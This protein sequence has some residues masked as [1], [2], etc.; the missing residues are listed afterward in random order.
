MNMMSSTTH[1]HKKLQL[2]APR[3]N[4]D[5]TTP[6]SCELQQP[7]KKHLHHPNLNCSPRTPTL[8]PSSTHDCRCHHSPSTVTSLPISNPCLAGAPPS[9]ALHLHSL[10]V[11]IVLPL[12]TLSPKHRVVPEP[13]HEDHYMS[14]FNTPQPL[15]SCEAPPPHRWNHH[16]TSSC[17]PLSSGRTSMATVK[18]SLPSPSPFLCLNPN[19]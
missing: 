7:Q 2:Q 5:V 13:H 12:W 18:W 19:P 8:P 4:Q 3:R 9:A 15:P 14:L 1:K 10:V 16:H 17:P 11:V 6:M